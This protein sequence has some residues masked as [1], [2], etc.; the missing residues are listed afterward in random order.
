MSDPKMNQSTT[1]DQVREQLKDALAEK[2]G[3]TQKL[4]EIERRI[5]EIEN[6]R[7]Q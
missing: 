7:Q 2:Q 3:A 4:N 6:S 1:R 5:R